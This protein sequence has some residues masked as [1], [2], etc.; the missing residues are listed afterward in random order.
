M[1]IMIVWLLFEIR[2]YHLL[3]PFII[4]YHPSSPIITHYHHCLKGSFEAPQTSLPLKIK[5]LKA[6][7]EAYLF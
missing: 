4:L 5:H 6:S 3:T 7:H 2:L 1:M